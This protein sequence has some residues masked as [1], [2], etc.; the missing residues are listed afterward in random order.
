MSPTQVVSSVDSFF[1]GVDYEPLL[2]AW[3]ETSFDDQ[4]LADAPVEARHILKKA[5][6]IYKTGYSEDEYVWADWL[7]L[8]EELGEQNQGVQVGLLG[9]LFLRHEARHHLDYYSTPLGWFF[10]SLVA[11]Q[12]FRLR[13]FVQ[14]REGTPEEDDIVRRLDRFFRAQ[15]LIVGNVPRL[16]KKLWRDVPLTERQ[17]KL[18]IFRYRVDRTDPGLAIATVEP[19]G[20][21]ERE[22]SVSSILEARAVI[23][24]SGYMAGRLRAAEATDRQ[25]VAAIKLLLSLCIQMARDDY[26]VLLN[27]GLPAVGLDEAAKVLAGRGPRCARLMLATWFGLH[28]ELP[29]QEIEVAAHPPLRLLLALNEL[30]KLSE[31]E[32]ARPN[33]DWNN[34][35]EQLSKLIG[36]HSLT[37][38]AASHKMN[39]EALEQTLKNGA[40]FAGIAREHLMYLVTVARRGMALRS[41]PLNWLDNVGWPKFEDP[42][43]VVDWA[44]PPPNIATAWSRLTRV[45]NQIRS[46]S[47]SA[48][49]ETANSLF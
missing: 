44:T 31:E 4:L 35:L 47:R 11:G 21:P 40:K 23:E 2:A 13:Q 7:A 15:D 14:T 39:L 10:P 38:T 3:P 45:R 34:V 48:A 24:T 16:E 5:Y 26:W 32:L 30:L 20:G 8:F 9:L 43:V 41:Q 46:G 49:R 17:T 42:A 12:Y 6:A 36:A 28:M 18:G 37:D 1:A 25:I 33:I 29:A 22:L 27:V 19:T